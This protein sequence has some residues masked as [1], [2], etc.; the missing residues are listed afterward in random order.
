MRVLQEDSSI[1]P[2]DHPRG[3]NMVTETAA[4]AL[5]HYILL[6]SERDVERERAC[7]LLAG[8]A[9]ERRDVNFNFIG[10]I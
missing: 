7:C 5:S 8:R 4:A 6:R 2:S 10:Q 9:G 1:H 3:I